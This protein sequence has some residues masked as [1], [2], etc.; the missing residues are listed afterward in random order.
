MVLLV[1]L[2][3]DVVGKAMPA[4]MVPVAVLTVIRLSVDMAM[5]AASCAFSNV[6]VQDVLSPKTAKALT[7]VGAAAF[8]FG[9]MENKTKTTR[10]KNFR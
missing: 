2:A 7:A 10:Q 9:R 4:A 5:M 6:N 1:S 3:Y 8:S